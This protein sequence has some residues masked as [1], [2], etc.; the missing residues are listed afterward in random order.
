MHAQK[1]TLASTCHSM[2]MSLMTNAAKERQK[3]LTEYAL[4]AGLAAKARKEFDAALIEE[5]KVGAFTFGPNHVTAPSRRPHRPPQ[6]HACLPCTLTV[7]PGCALAR[8][9]LP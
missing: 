7:D 1:L 6:G 3:A 5:K 2:L 8:I 4:N 9:A